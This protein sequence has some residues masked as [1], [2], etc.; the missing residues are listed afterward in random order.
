MKLRLTVNALL[1]AVLISGVG[2]NVAAANGL[3]AAEI[4]SVS[5]IESS[6]YYR[7]VRTTALIHSQ[8]LVRASAWRALRSADG[9]AAL[10]RYI[11]TGMNEAKQLAE[12][13]EA[14]NLD[15]ARRI[16][17][18]YTAQFSP[19]VHA[20]ALEAIDK[21]PAVQE[22]FARVGF[23]EAKALDDAGREADEQHKQQILE[24]DRDFVRLLAQLDP[25]E[26]VRL[27]AQYALRNGGTDVDLRV[28]FATDWMAAAALD[29]DLH[30]MRTLEAGVKFHAVIQ[31][32]VRDAKDAERE[33]LA[34][35]GAAAELARAVAARAWATTKERA[36][37]ARQA[38][39][40]EA[41][42][43]AEQARYWRTVIERAQ[44]SS[45]PV[46]A[47]IAATADKNRGAWTGDGTLAGGEQQYWAGVE[48]E[49][50]EGYLRMTTPA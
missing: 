13:Q 47:A 43:C 26:Q 30:R 42:A 25:G 37:A 29:I 1:V 24:V 22:H 10:L 40:D 49:A 31:Q 9:D 17:K 18:T 46:W 3:A 12:K 32:L 16:A 48:N 36:D 44:S 28:F 23:A 8:E 39:E 33:A 21:G 5:G 11:L 27:A 4:A 35:S 14:R 34:A 20:A 45:D 19:R 15:F 6:P 41:A 50:H 38:W 2:T 7:I